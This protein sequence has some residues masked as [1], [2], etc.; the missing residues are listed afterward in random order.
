MTCTCPVIIEPS[1]ERTPC[2]LHEG[3]WRDGVFFRRCGDSDTTGEPYYVSDPP[4][5]IEVVR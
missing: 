5:T 1:E 4:I 3:F 2:P